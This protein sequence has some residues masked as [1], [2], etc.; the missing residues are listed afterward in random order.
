MH[1]ND[2]RR[3]FAGQGKVIKIQQVGRMMV[4]V[5]DGL[6]ANRENNSAVEEKVRKD[7]KELTAR[8]PIY[9]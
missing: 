7:V 3:E 9:S 6:A 4:E 2:W 5:L 8:F 1:V